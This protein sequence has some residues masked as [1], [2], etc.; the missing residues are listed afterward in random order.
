MEL[1]EHASKKNKME[2]GI[3]CAAVKTSAGSNAYHHHDFPKKIGLLKSHDEELLLVDEFE[4]QRR[5]HCVL[6]SRRRHGAA[7]YRLRYPAALLSFALHAGDERIEF[8]L[9]YLHSSANSTTTTAQPRIGAGKNILWRCFREPP[10]PRLPQDKGTT[11]I[12]IN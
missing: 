10:L 2:A 5:I 7:G 12:S 6:E 11:T 4:R 1:K 3:C 9:D 8:A